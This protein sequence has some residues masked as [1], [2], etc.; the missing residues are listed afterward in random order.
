M[1]EHAIPVK[2]ILQRIR[3][4]SFTMREKRCQFV[5]AEVT[6]LERI[7]GQGCR[8]PIMAKAL[9]VTQLPCPTTQAELET[10]LDSAGYYLRFTQNFAGV[11]SPLSDALR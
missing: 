6:Y 3:L 1:S 10:F 4:T 7:V 2:D 8:R 9:A 11:V 5:K